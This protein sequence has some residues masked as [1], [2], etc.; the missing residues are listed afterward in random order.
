MG[1]FDCEKE[2]NRFI[3]PY[4]RNCIDFLGVS[5]TEKKE[6]A[7]K[8]KL[9]N[10]AAAEKRQQ[11]FLVE[12]LESKEMIRHYEDVEDTV[13]KGQICFDI[14]LKN[15]SDENIKEL[16]NCMMTKAPFGDRK[17]TLVEQLARIPVTS[18]NGYQ[19]AANSHIGWC[20][21][22]KKVDSI[23][24][25]FL[26]RWCEENL[27]MPKNKGYMDEKYL[28]YLKNLNDPYFGT[29]A[30]KIERYLQRYDG[31]LW[32]FGLDLWEEKEKYKIYVKNTSNPYE[33]LCDILSE[34]VAMKLK[35]V[36]QWHSKNHN[37]KF[38]GFALAYDSDNEESCNLYFTE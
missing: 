17:K 36:E 37:W 38:A 26:T 28:L 10:R 3:A 7:I 32:L 11:H 13:N 16:Y 22:N 21:K 20:E 4:D 34:E 35:N 31:N 12:F 5:I 8:F 25:Y 30:T 23:K 27:D 19:Y 14:T 15:R 33:G 18:K 29:L 2:I 1:N 24:F 6:E 9:Y